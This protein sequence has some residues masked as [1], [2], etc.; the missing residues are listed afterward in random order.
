MTVTEQVPT[1]QT[2]PVEKVYCDISGRELGSRERW[3]LTGY[4]DN[5][6]HRRQA[7]LA[8]D[9]HAEFLAEFRREVEVTRLKL[10]EKGKPSA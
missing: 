6:H 7:F 2:Q 3:R 1:G 8:L 10:R 5:Y 4:E 9:I